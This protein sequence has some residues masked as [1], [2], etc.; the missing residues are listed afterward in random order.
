[1]GAAPDDKTVPYEDAPLLRRGVLK[2]ASTSWGSRVAAANLH[3][4]DRAVHRLSGGRHTVTSMITGLPIAMVTTT[5]ARSGQ[6]RT[7]PL[8]ALPTDGGMAVV[9]SN[10]GGPSHP[11]WVHNLRADPHGSITLTDDTAWDFL[12]DEVEGARRAQIWNEHARVYPGYTGYE[13]RASP[14]HIAVFDLHRM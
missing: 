2:V 10:H 5:G 11:G 13:Y 1:M 6:A 7:V 14:R 8:I 4:A 3:V 9:G 12:A